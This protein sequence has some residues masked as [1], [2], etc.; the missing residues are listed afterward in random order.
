M[1]LEKRVIAADAFWREDDAP[2]IEVQRME[3]VVAIARRLKFR[4]KSVMTQTV[5]RRARQLAQIADVSDAVATRAI[6]AYHFTAER[7]LMAAFLD[8]MG[9]PHDNGLIA[10][11]KAQTPDRERLPAAVA[12]LR[13]SFAEAD[14]DLYLRTL[15]ALDP[16]SWGCLESVL[17]AS[18]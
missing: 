12:A 8:A 18:L 16:E 4:P 17:G 13:S 3:A 15:A 7:P 5:E 1:P 11:E 2:D 14:I 9:I 10:D 6:I